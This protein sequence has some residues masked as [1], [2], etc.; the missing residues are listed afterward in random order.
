MNRS[1][2]PLSPEE[3]AL[4]ERLARLDVRREP[5]PA[6]DAAILASARAA[7]DGGIVAAAARTAA[8]TASTHA[9]ST[10]AVSTSAQS[11][12][13]PSNVVSIPVRKPMP[14]WP[15]GLSLAASLV[16]AAGIG[17][18][19]ADGDGGDSTVQTATQRAQSEQ[20]VYADAVAP[21]EQPTQA[22]MLEPELNRIPPPPPPPPLEA[23]AERRAVAVESPRF[24][25]QKAKRLDDHKDRHEAFEMDEGI[26]QDAVADT[27]NAGG[28]TAFPAE[29]STRSSASSE[30]SGVAAKPAAASDAASDGFAARAR[31]KR[32]TAKSDREQELDKLQNTGSRVAR[33]APTAPAAAPAATAPPPT[34]PAATGQLFD[35]QPPVS[36]DSPQF[37]QAWLQRIRDLFTSGQTDAG[38][39]SLQEFRRRYPSAELP[40]DLK[41]I[42]ATL[43]PPTP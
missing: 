4:A 1:T 31:E 35:E 5:A 21:A 43:P 30:T 8:P 2:E 42:A 19:L 34:P 27:A 39:N 9:Q 33:H 41:K 14:R 36:A 37:R 23:Q 40:E 11:S 24:E 13:A 10:D 32:E 26:A 29:S 7:V 12:E 17:W 16:M 15:L 22:V 18:R 6:L 3:R 38:R 20:A 28:G 25:E